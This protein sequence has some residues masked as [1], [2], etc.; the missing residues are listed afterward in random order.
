MEPSKID[1]SSSQLYL[2]DLSQYLD[3]EKLKNLIKDHQDKLNESETKSLTKAFLVYIEAKMRKEGLY[4]SSSALHDHLKTC[5]KIMMQFKQTQ[6][7]LELIENPQVNQ[8]K[9]GCT[10][11]HIGANCLSNQA[12]KGIGETSTDETYAYEMKLVPAGLTPCFDIKIKLENHQFIQVKSQ[13]Q[14]TSTNAKHEEEADQSDGNPNT[15]VVDDGQEDHYNTLER[16]LARSDPINASE[17]GTSSSPGSPSLKVHCNTLTFP[18]SKT[19]K[20]PLP[21]K[22]HLW[23]TF[24][25]GA[26][27]IHLESLLGYVQKEDLI[28]LL[29]QLPDEDSQMRMLNTFKAISGD[30]AAGTS[31]QYV[32]RKLGR[33]FAYAID[34]SYIYINSNR[35]P[36]A[37]GTFKEVT[38]AFQ[39]SRADKIKNIVRVKVKKPSEDGKSEKQI[40]KEHQAWI[41]MTIEEGLLLERIRRESHPA[42]THLADPYMCG[43]LT[44]PS[45]DKVDMAD[46]PLLIKGNQANKYSLKLFQTGYQSVQQLR[47]PSTSIDQIIDYF[48]VITT[49]IDYL[50]QMNLVYGDFK[51]SNTMMKGEEVK[52]IDFGTVKS[53]GTC[54]N[55]GS[56]PY[57]PPEAVSSTQLYASNELFIANDAK[58]SP[59]IDSW[60]IGCG[61]LE[62]LCHSSWPVTLNG[63]HAYLSSLN[64]EQLDTVKKEVIS[65]IKS[66]T[67]GQEQDKKR[68]GLVDICFA[69]LK[70]VD[71]RMTVAQAKEALVK[72]K[73]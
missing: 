4:P 48:I 22:T 73:G 34:S 13:I 70:N 25:Q 43:F 27:P 37:K 59:M 39:I 60:S 41:H 33:T 20:Q 32:G 44:I 2:N 31:S 42:S 52:L 12:I 17:D 54:L 9:I 56:I 64:A 23:E 50:H 24:W 15:S 35:T 61:M 58:V 46:W 65:Y 71:Q 1:H 29:D 21:F 28:S 72:L 14:H 51:L 67:K 10:L 36:A 66:N 7:L 53:A 5:I 19:E 8:A 68:L 38:G 45:D 40:R 47:D 62:L 26:N 6:S 49:A 30:L 69:L 3:I 57:L 55:A 16:A 63:R 11:A 18:H